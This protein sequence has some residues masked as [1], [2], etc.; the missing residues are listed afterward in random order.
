MRPSCGWCAHGWVVKGPLLCSA[1]PAP[2]LAQQRR[3][4]GGGGGARAPP[5]PPAPAP[6]PP[7]PAPPAGGGGGG[8]GGVASQRVPTDRVSHAHVR[9][10]A[11]RVSGDQARKLIARLPPATARPRAR[12]ISRRARRGQWPRRTPAR[13]SRGARTRRH[14]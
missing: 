11:G 13:S 5:P 8:G 4:G 10:A 3:G 14:E 9:T 2:L 6:P 1:A 7:P 12:A